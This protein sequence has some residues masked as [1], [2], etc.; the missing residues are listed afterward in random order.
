[1]SLFRYPEDSGIEEIEKMTSCS[2]IPASARAKPTP[3]RVSI[4]DNEID[5]FRQL[6]KLSRISKRTYENVQTD[7]R[8]GLSRE[9]LVDAKKAWEDDYDW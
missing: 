7:R 8:F 6:L 9:W 4:P 5:E 2:T 1:M 3:F